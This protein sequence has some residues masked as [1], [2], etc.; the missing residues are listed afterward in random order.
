MNREPDFT[1]K[2]FYL[3]SEQGGRNSF[4][5]SGYRPHI[6]FSHKKYNTSGQQIF[7]NKEIVKPGE[8]VEAEITIIAIE[9]FRNELYPGMLFKFCEGSR[10]IGF[11]EII[12]IINKELEKK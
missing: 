3:T 6:Q 8:N 12:E 9:E 1:A 5:S 10:I 7:L 11:G 2:L 4:A